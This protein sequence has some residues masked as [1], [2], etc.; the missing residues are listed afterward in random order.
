[1]Q[2]RKI[3]CFSLGLLVVLLLGVW[4][5]RRGGG[6]EV[7]N[8][9]S[10]GTDIIAFG[11]SLVEGVGA[12]SKEKNFVSLL[13]QKIEKPIVNL[14]VSGDTTEAGLARVSQIGQYKPR[15]VLLLLSGNDRLRRIPEEQTL[16]NLGKIITYIQDRGAMVVLLG[17]RGNVLSNSF[18]KKL[19]QLSLDYKTAYVPDVL[20]GLFGNSEYMSDPIHPNDLGYEKVAEKVYPVL[21]KYMK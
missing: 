19:E 1:M 13:S 2:S 10:S 4:F 21:V 11:D 20:D 8:Y 9:P 5:M 14:G 3:I 7:K 16:E 6:V 12:S 15:I 18:D 17:V